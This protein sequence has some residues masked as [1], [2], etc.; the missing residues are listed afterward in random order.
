MPIC[1]VGDDARNPADV[2]SCPA[3]P[4]DVVGPAVSGSP[5]VTVNDLPVLRLCDKG[6]HSTCCASCDW[7][8]IE[9]SSTVTVNSRP[10]VRLQD[11]TRHCGGTGAMIE[12]SSDAEIG[13]PAVR[14]RP[15]EEVAA[16]IHREMMKNLRGNDMIYLRENLERQWHD[17]LLP[18]KHD[19]D[20]AQ[21]YWRWYNLVRTGGPWDHKKEIIEKF[22]YWSYDA[23]TDNSHSYETWSNIHYGYIGRASGFPQWDLLAG[24]GLAQLKDGNS[25]PGYWSRRFGTIF[26][27]DFLAAFDE[28][29]D[30][31]A[32]RIGMDL[33]EN[34][35]DQ[36][37]IQN[38]T[39]AIRASSKLKTKLGVAC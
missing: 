3:C 21:A 2:H 33:W 12:G 39:D 25:P 17:A 36:V 16:F 7:E 10:V 38:I 23:T 1:R 9:G 5:D 30:Q 26:D 15:L 4:H 28:S 20:V 6:T 14:G 19:F 34:H 32:I 11:A 8:A 22:G 27:A 24:A 18:G 35:G 13:G 37:T 31:E 29:E